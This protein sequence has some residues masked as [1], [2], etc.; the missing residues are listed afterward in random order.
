MIAISSDSRADLKASLDNFNAVMPIPLVSDGKLGAFKAYRVFDDFEQQ[1]LHGTFII[2]GH[3][4]VRW[5]DI[6]YEPFLD[7]DF[8]LKEAKRLLAQTSEPQGL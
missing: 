3:G 1:P 6:S 2:D 5:Q 4:K 8:V 7:P